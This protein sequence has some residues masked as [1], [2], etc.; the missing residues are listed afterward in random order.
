MKGLLRRLGIGSDFSKDSAT[1]IS[2]TAVAQAISILAVPI[3][4]RIYH[5]EDYGVLGL[6]MS[7]AAVIG[8]FSTLQYSTAILLP[9][10]EADAD[11]LVALCFVA[12][13]F[14]S[15]VCL[16]I[17]AALGESIARLLNAPTLSFWLWF[18]PVSIFLIV[19][20]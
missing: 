17:V 1:L 11:A 14:L 19:C 2:G 8:V 20:T 7:I 13:A 4:A 3:L 16:V 6:Y 15:M 12:T 9:A 18:T 5:P 10:D